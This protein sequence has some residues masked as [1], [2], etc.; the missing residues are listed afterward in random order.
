MSEQKTKIASKKNVKLIIIFA[1]LAALVILIPIGYALF[2]DKDKD[3]NDTTI[4]KINVSLEEDWPPRGETYTDPTNPGESEEYDEFGIKKYTKKVWGKTTEDLP[5]YVRI[6]CIPIV[7]YNTD[8]TNGQ[9]DWVIAPVPQESIV[10]NIT[11]ANDD[12][13]ATWVYSNGYWYYK[14]ILK[15]KN[16][17]TTKMDINWQIDE[18]PSELQGYHVRADVRVIL[19]YAQTTHDMWKDIFQIESLPEGVEQ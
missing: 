8:K 4:G 15:Q 13:G 2:S 5:A 19:E 10:V 18:L 12:N 16:D 14:K 3:K 11:P 1:L 9:G 7:E 17:E 6:K